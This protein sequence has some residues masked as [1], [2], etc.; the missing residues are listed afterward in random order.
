MK[1]NILSGCTV[2]YEEDMPKNPIKGVNKTSID[3]PEPEPFRRTSPLDEIPDNF[4]ERMM[5]GA[6]KG[7]GVKK[8]ERKT[9]PEGFA[10]SIAYNKGGYQLVPKEDV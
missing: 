10:V 4:V 8:P 3:R 7:G 6:G 1:Q 2:E 5:A 9:I